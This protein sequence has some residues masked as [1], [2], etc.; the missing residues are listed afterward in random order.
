MET[1]LRRGFLRSGLVRW[2]ATISHPY[3]T[4]RFP[5]G[6][7]EAKISKTTEQAFIRDAERELAEMMAEVAGTEVRHGPKRR[8]IDQDR[9]L[10]EARLGVLELEHHE[11]AAD[12]EALDD[13]E[14]E[15]DQEPNP[16]AN[17]RFMRGA[18]RELAELIRDVEGPNPSAAP[19]RQPFPG[20][21][22]K[23]PIPSSVRTTD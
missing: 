5:P 11:V 21:V 16:E 1:L 9:D 12:L 10:L 13:H 4:L 18:R 14:P 2:T 17:V 20:S 22:R 23:G 19:R 3:P 15:D 7:E 8:T 6:R